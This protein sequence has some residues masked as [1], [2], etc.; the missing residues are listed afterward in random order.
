MA[1][2]MSHATSNNQQGNFSLQIDRMAQTAMLG[3]FMNGIVLYNWYT[4]LELSFG[5]DMKNRKTVFAKMVADQFIYAPFSIAVFFSS[6]SLQKHR[7]LEECFEIFVTKMHKTFISTYL[8]DCML[9]PF[10]NFLNFRF[11]PLFLRFVFAFV[12]M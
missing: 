7:T 11:V 5:S 3:L 12:G 8:A 6:S 2:A 10:V 4:V 1:Q 9:W